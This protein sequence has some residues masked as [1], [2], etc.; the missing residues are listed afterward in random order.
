MSGG[1]TSFFSEGDGGIRTG[2]FCFTEKCFREVYRHVSR[3]G[4]GTDV[5]R[6]QGAFEFIQSEAC[7]FFSGVLSGNAGSGD[8][9]DW[10]GVVSA[11][12]VGGCGNS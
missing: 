6:S 3:T 11:V 5:G 10:S 4:M 12:N 9:C 1:G 2:V 8:G 7:S